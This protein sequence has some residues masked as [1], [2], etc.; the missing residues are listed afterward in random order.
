M[1]ILNKLFQ[2]N[3]F[4]ANIE[5]VFQHSIVCSALKRQFFSQEILGEERLPTGSHEENNALMQDFTR[6]YLT[7]LY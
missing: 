6:L 5:C 7:M 3:R 4:K 1:R 2:N